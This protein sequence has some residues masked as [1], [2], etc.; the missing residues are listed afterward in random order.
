M[1]PLRVEAQVD[2]PH[3]NRLAAISGPRALM[4]K[5]PTRKE[6]F[7]INE[8]VREIIAFTRDEALNDGVLIETRL[9]EGLPS[10]Q[11]DRVLLQHVILNLIVNAIE[12]IRGLGE[13]PR[14][15]PISS[16]RTPDGVRVAI[17]DSGRG[18]P[19][20][21]IERLFEAFYPTK[22]GGR[23]MGLPFCRKIIER[24]GG[25]LWATVNVPGIALFQFTVPV[26]RPPFAGARASGRQGISS[27]LASRA[28]TT[29]GYGSRR[30]PLT[31]APNAAVG[32]SEPA[33]V[34]AMAAAVAMVVALSLEYLL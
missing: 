2:L 19:L 10:V 4:H 3:P 7:D 31:S 32:R 33:A 24:H 20:D 13:R 23:G 12:T 17:A 29:R 15:L 16:S 8:A 25:R 18:L 27:C 22:P 5:E 11:G 6:S 21:R 9:A 28:R 1:N 34:V 30:C 14:E 26:H